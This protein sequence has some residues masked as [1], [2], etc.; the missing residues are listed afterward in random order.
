MSVDTFIDELFAAD[1][2]V[3]TGGLASSTTIDLTIKRFVLDLLI[4]RAATVV[5]TRDVMPVLKNL[6]LHARPGQLRLVGSDNEITIIA[7]TD[8]VDVAAAGVAV[9]PARQLAEIVKEAD[10]GDVRIRV[11]GLRATITIGRTEWNLVLVSGA[12]YPPQPGIDEAVFETVD[13]AAYLAA[14]TCVR[15]A[16]CRAAERANLM[17]IHVVDGRMTAC[18]GARI[19]QAVVPVGLAHQIPIGA[20]DLLI[21]LLRSADLATIAVGEAGERLVYRLG[22]DILCINKLVAVFPDAEA[23]YLRPAMANTH[24]LGLDR[25][26]LLDAIRRVRITADTNTSAIALTVDAGRLV[27]TARDVIGNNAHETVDAEW[28][29]PARTLVVNHRFLV[30]LIGQ[31]P[32]TRL[33]FRLGADT[34]TRRSPLLLHNPDTGTAGVVQQMN[35]DWTTP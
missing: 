19:A 25:R 4:T 22:G 26:D 13:R 29:G 33:V 16:A 3:L 32:D 27:V 14:L 15:Y 31:H 17:M 9:F 18:D 10:E 28:A 34:A 35:I 1:A 12:D 5:P 2:P 6:Q 24:T 21:K 8:L 30:D 20:V 7:T 23:L 11:D